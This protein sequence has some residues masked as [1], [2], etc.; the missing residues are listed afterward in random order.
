M[1]SE[2]LDWDGPKV[3][4]SRFWVYWAFMIPSTL[5]VFIIWMILSVDRPITKLAGRAV[6]SYQRFRHN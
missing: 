2:S 4:T 6:V 1:P 5:V 3:I